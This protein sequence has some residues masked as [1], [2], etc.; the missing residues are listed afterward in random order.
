MIGNSVMKE[1]S[2]KSANNI[3]V[4]PL[5]L[6]VHKKSH[7]IY[8][9][10]RAAENCTFLKYAWPLCGSRRQRVNVQIVRF[11]QT[12]ILWSKQKLK[13]NGIKY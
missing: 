13:L 12:C 2:N 6:G 5:M 3:S 7:I 9:K 8:L 10:K 1:F 11:K 4:N